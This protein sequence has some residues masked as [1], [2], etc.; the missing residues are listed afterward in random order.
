MKRYIRFVYIYLFLIT[1]LFIGAFA[2]GGPPQSA[3]PMIPTGEAVSSTFE[4]ATPGTQVIKVMAKQFEFIPNEI[5]GKSGIP[6][7]IIL[8]SEDVTHGFAI[9]D[10]KI[11]VQVRKGEDTIVDFTPDKPGT[12]DFYCSVFCGIGHPGMRGK[13]IV[14]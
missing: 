3:A 4:V 7:R 11:N 12:Y 1:A 14:Q 13:L 9:D 10:L 6:V 8:T 5:T 2:M